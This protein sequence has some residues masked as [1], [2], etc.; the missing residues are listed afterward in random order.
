MN[1]S[2]RDL[3][4]LA[5]IADDKEELMDLMDRLGVKTFPTKDN[6]RSIMLQVAYKQLIQHPKYHSP[7]SGK[8]SSIH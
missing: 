5:L 4:Y 8:H 7:S 2:E 1:Q 6:Q 3:T